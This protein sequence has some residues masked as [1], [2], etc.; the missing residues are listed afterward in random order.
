MLVKHEYLY[1]VL[2][3]AAR[4]GAVIPLVKADMIA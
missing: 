4:I 3:D 2:G 1:L